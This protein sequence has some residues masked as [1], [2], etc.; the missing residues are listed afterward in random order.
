MIDIDQIVGAINRQR[1]AV[2]R[3]RSLLVGITG[4]DG[5]GKGYLTAKIVARLQQMG[6]KTANINVNGWLNL[7]HIRFNRDNPAENFYRRGLRLDEMFDQLI[8]PLKARRSIRLTADYVEET[9]AEYRPHLYEYQNVDI[10]LLE[11]IY[12]L[13]RA[14]QQHF[15]LSCWVECTFET[16]LARVVKRQTVPNNDLI[17]VYRTIY[18]PA[19]RIHLERDNPLHAAAE[20]IVNDPRITLVS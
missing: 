2:S 5:S 12:L 15:D 20:I 3:E 7:P 16:A 13:K 9:A 14:Y 10:I 6:F 17:T 4:I 1:A 18:F 19:Q 8:L 11:G